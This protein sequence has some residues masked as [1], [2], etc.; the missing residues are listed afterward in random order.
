MH[1]DKSPGVDGFPMEFFTSRWNTNQDDV[2]RVV[3]DIFIL[4][5]IFKSSSCMI[6]SLIP[7]YATP[8]P[9]KDFKPIT[10]CN[11]FYKLIIKILTNRIKEVIHTII[12]PSQSTFIEGGII[13]NLLFQS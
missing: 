7:K 5:K 12:G 4:R 10:C 8:T 1:V 13:D 6:V 11:T 3:K 9:I 2:I